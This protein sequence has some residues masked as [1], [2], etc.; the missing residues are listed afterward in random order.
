M[1]LFTVVLDDMNIGDMSLEAFQRVTQPKVEGSIHL[2]NIFHGHLDFLIYLSSISSVIG[3]PGQSAYAAANMFMLSLAEQRRQRGLAASVVHIGPILGAGYITEKDHDTTYMLRSMASV[4]MSEH[5]FHQLFAEGILAGSPQSPGGEITAGIRQVRLSE[6]AQPKWGTNPMM[7]HMLLES[8]DCS[9]ATSTSSRTHVPLDRQLSEA[10]SKKEIHRIVREAVSKKLSVLFRHELD[11]IDSETLEATRLDE[12]G[13]DSLMAVEIRGWLMQTLKV[14]YPVLKILS[15]ISVGQLIGAAVAGVT[16]NMS[17]KAHS[18]PTEVVT[19]RQFTEDPELASNARTDTD[20]P[21]V[22]TP[23]S[24]TIHHTAANE[25]EGSDWSSSQVVAS[26][27][28]SHTDDPIS[29]H[30]C[31]SVTEIFDLSYTQR[32]FWFASRLFED[33]T[34]LN[35][36]AL[37]H[38]TGPLRT[39][40]LE[41]AVRRLGQDH[42][43]LRTYIIASRERLEQ[44]VMGTSALQLEHYWISKEEEA[45]EAVRRIQSKHYHTDRGETLCLKLLSLSSTDHF[46]ILGGTGLVMDGL[47]SQVFLRDLARYYHDTSGRANQVVPQYRDFV[48]AQ[49]RAVNS[50]EMDKELAFWKAQYPNFPSPLPVLLV[51]QST[52]RPTL[53]TFSHVRMDTRVGLETKKQIRDICRQFRITPFHFYLSCFR[54]LISRLTDSEDVSIGVGDAHRLDHSSMNCIGSFFNVLPLRFRTS[55]TSMFND[56]LRD[57]CETTYKGLENSR[58]PFQALLDQ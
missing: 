22:D 7:G 26:V 21:S 47:S 25:G 13:I 35:H 2:N 46:L 29:N 56:V 39:R 58:L 15:G 33:N 8:E 55:T 42:E 43:S 41:Q 54:A 3:I 31:E 10:H 38:L 52:S 28:G 5:D 17:P 36:T 45:F 6:V 4:H 20:L 50:G 30:Q 11:T 19:K 32:M 18:T 53:T 12:L 44:G 51:S 24:S 48:M 9:N 34:S 16:P 37:F 57:T 1:L 40:D 49:N 14:N 23:I 27:T